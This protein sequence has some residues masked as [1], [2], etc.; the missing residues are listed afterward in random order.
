MG[1]H[2]AASGATGRHPRGLQ[3]HR[4]SV[5]DQALT[6]TEIRQESLIENLL[7]E[8]LRPIEAAQ[9]Y[10]QLMELNGWTIQQVADALNITKGTVSK[11]LS[12]LKLPEDIRAQVEEGQ[13]APTVAY[14]ISRVEGEGAQRELA[15]RV[16]DEGLKRDDAGQL[17]GRARRGRGGRAKPSTTKVFEV[18][19]GRVTV[20]WA[21]ESVRPEDIIAALGEAIAQ[22]KG[23]AA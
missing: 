4:L 13:I 23:R 7:R 22:A 9:G 6:E 19:G 16:V 21:R 17:A 1:H 5:L 18:D 20:T 15:R 2:L 3:D 12:L 11:A 14:E 10:Q 8:D